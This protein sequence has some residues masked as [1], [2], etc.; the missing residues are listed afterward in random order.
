MAQMLG[1]QTHHR[2]GTL[3]QVARA[4]WPVDHGSMDILPRL[5]LAVVEHYRGTGRLQRQLAQVGRKASFSSRHAP[6]PARW[7]EACV[8]GVLGR[9]DQGPYGD[10]KGEGEAHRAFNAIRPDG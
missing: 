2:I 5:G 1:A 10:D 6:G 3:L 9:R 8:Q 4:H 7:C